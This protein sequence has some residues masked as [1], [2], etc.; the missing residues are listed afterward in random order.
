M[1]DNIASVQL[2]KFCTLS[3]ST[4]I[5]FWED[6]LEVSVDLQELNRD[7]SK[8]AQ[9]LSLVVPLKASAI[10]CGWDLTISFQPE[11]SITS[12][13]WRVFMNSIAWQDWASFHGFH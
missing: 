2:Y 10:K 9:H 13:T 11:V 4:S 6:P 12:V 1:I 7:V 8:I 3:L 5:S